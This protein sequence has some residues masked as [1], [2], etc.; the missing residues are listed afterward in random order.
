MAKL[1][2]QLVKKS[3]NSP[4]LNMCNRFLLHIKHSSFN[5][6]ED[7]DTAVRRAFDRIP[8]SELIKELEKLKTHF[9]GVIE[10]SGVYL[11][12]VFLFK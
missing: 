7:V 12:D 1:N 9:D 6:P 5:G 4:D 8:E 11:F 2:V 3:P 10:Q